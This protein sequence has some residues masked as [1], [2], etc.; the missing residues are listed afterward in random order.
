MYTCSFVYRGSIPDE[1]CSC[2]SIA[3]DAYIIADVAPP[4]YSAAFNDTPI[5]DNRTN[6]LSISMYIRALEE[7]TASLSH[8]RI[9]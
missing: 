1:C 7:H 9:C 6:K 5:A 3:A 2:F 4:Q 8:C